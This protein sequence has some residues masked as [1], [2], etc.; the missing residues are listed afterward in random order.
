MAFI[1]GVGMGISK[2]EDRIGDEFI[3]PKGGI[4]KVVGVSNNKSGRSAKHI[5]E[6]SI[7]S[8]D[9]ELFTEPF[10]ILYAK[11]VSGST[12]CACSRYCYSERQIKVLIERKCKLLN[13]TF[14]GFEGTF[15]DSRTTKPIIKCRH[16]EDLHT[17][18]CHH[19]INYRKHGC[20]QCASDNMSDNLLSKYKFPDNVESVKSYPSLDSE[21]REYFYRCK[22]CSYDKFVV[23]GY[24]DGNFNFLPHRLQKGF[25]SCRCSDKYFGSDHYKLGKAILAQDNNTNIVIHKIVD[26]D[27]IGTCSIHG[28]FRQD[29]SSCCEGRIPKCCSP[30][31]WYIRKG[32]EHDQD[33]MYIMKVYLDD[34]EFIKIGRAFDIRLRE[35]ELS[36]YYNTELIYFLKTD[37]IAI[38]KYEKFYHKVF[39]KY[40]QVSSIR[41]KGDGELFSMD[42]LDDPNFKLLVENLIIDT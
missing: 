30:S 7:C 6:C 8:L 28:E 31:G 1:V 32:R 29:Y 15:V 25:L 19:Y 35:D 21:N 14:E 41:F 2:A 38:C 27:A 20:N 3:T 16:G 36:C 42:I 34:E 39:K 13:H 18:S 22:Y 17:N 40:K 33:H 23:N 11:L 37:H 24:C 26:D 5:V 10:E 4:L 9:K 12:P